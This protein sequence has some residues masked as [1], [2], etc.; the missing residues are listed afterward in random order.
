MGYI[1]GSEAAIFLALTC[2]V[3]GCVVAKRDL[4]ILVPLGTAK[5]LAWHV[6]AKIA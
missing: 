2:Q 3:K 6:S 4:R 1:L 5:T